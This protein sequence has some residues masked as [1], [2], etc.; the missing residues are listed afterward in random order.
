M[1]DVNRL[2]AFYDELM[3]IHIEKYPDWRFG[4]LIWNFERW[5]QNKKGIFDAFYIEEN[6]M[7]CLIREFSTKK[8]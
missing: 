3:Q 8:I 5:L 6:E 1:R 7:I 2:Y 4:Q